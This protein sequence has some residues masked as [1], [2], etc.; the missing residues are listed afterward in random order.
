ML[1][2]ES[3]ETEEEMIAIGH[4]LGD[5]PLVA[6]MVEGGR[7]PIARAARGWPRSATRS[8]SFR[9]RAYSAPLRRSTRSIAR[10]A[11]PARRSA[12]PRRFIPSPR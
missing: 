6:N 5:K 1:F 11:R 10:S 9:S 7:T 12:R 3:P 2:V 4:E 8:R